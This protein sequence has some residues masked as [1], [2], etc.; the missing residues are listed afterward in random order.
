MK[1]IPVLYQKKSDC[2]G[3]GACLNICPR[4][5]IRMAADE[6][7]FL[8]PKIDSYLCVGCRKCISV[9]AFQNIN[10]N[11]T[12]LNTYAAVLQNKEQAVKSASGGIFAS[13]AEDYLNKG[14][15]VFGAAFDEKE[16]FH[17]KVLTRR[18]ICIFYRGLNMFRVK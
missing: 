10:E 18:K 2:C 11:N 3:C 4:N 17:I 13:L 16:E 6:C 5:A 9:C 8:Y 15:I 1:K 14:G 7:G 12:P